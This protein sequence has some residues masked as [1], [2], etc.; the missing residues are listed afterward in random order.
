MTTFKE[1]EQRRKAALYEYEKEHKQTLCIYNFSL[2]IIE[3]GLAIATF[4]IVWG[5]GYECT[6]GPNMNLVIWLIFGMHLINSIE[7]VFKASGLASV[8][9]GPICRIG[10][11]VY[12]IAV[13]VYM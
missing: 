11:F 1:K 9:C 3:I 12:E 10:F 7:A 13:L 8:F 2:T 4:Y 6:N 5:Y